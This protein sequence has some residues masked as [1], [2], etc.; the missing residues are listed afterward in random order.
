MEPNIQNTINIPKK[1]K[2]VG[3]IIFNILFSI[4]YLPVSF[5]IIEIFTAPRFCIDGN[6]SSFTSFHVPLLIIALFIYS[7]FIL[8]GLKRIRKMVLITLFLILI[9]IVIISFK[10]IMSELKYNSSIPSRQILVP[11]LPTNNQ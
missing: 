4:I 11:E 9:A 2:K 8:R 7:L 3:K 6:C 1:P 5:V 10:K